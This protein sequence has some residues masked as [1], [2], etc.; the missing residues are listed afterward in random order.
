LKKKF[1]HEKQHTKKIRTHS[2]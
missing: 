2:C 1:K